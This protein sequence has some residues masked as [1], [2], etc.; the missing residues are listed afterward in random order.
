MFPGIFGVPNIKGVFT[1]IVSRSNCTATGSI[2]SFTANVG[3]N[4]VAGTGDCIDRG[5]ELNASSSSALFGASSSVQPA[6]LYGLLLI[7]FQ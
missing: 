1:P 6:G 7:R 3:A 2:S 5:I 4:V